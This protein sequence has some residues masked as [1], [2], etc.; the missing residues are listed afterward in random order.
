MSDVSEETAANE[1]PAQSSQ[2]RWAFIDASNDSR[3]N[4]T[5]V[6]RHVMQ[7]Y[8]RQKRGGEP[9]PDNENGESVK[10]KEESQPK[11]RRRPRNKTAGKSTTEKEKKGAG[12]GWREKSPDASTDT[13]RGLESMRE[14][15][16][17]EGSSTGIGERH[18]SAAAG[19]TK[20]DIIVSVSSSDLPKFY[21]SGD[22]S[23]TSESDSRSPLSSAPTTPLRANPL[24]QIDSQRSAN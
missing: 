20:T 17:G 12:K 2:T 24:S 22:Q 13:Q 18:A 23:S 5:R 8:M 11:G 14:D 15:S 1:P 6:K 19:Q 7:E 10:E 16:L 21:A 9:Q 4:L 3:S